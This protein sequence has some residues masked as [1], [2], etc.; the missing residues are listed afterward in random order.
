VDVP[1]GAHQVDLAW[2]PPAA[3]PSALAA[4]LGA[5]LAVA[6]AIARVV[7][8]RRSGRVEAASPTEP[9]PVIAEPVASR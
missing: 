4:L 7:R 5:A 9:T 6:H 8:R 1:A 3:V 2:S